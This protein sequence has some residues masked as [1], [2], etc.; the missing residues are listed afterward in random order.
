MDEPA[1]QV[2][3]LYKDVSSTVQ[4]PFAAASMRVWFEAG[5]F[6]E[7]TLIAKA[8]ELQTL[9]YPVEELWKRPASQAFHPKCLPT[10]PAASSL[11][12]TSLPSKASGVSRGFQEALVQ[13]SA[14]AHGPEGASSEES[15]SAEAWAKRQRLEIEKEHAQ[16]DVVYTCEDQDGEPSNKVIKRM[17]IQ[18]EQ[19]RYNKDWTKAEQVQAELRS[20]GVEVVRPRTKAFEGL[21]RAADGRTGPLP[22][23]SMKTL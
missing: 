10:F 6:T 19:H 8:G 4:G 7:K 5:Y 18:R 21:W 15:S 23:L 1:A 2:Q 13:Q 17:L 11:P 3:W 20:I 9:W 14:T 22:K 12:A 16:D